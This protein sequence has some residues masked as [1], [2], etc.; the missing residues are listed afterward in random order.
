MSNLTTGI[1]SLLSNLTGKIQ[2]TLSSNFAS[3]GLINIYER[4]ADPALER[5]ILSTG[6]SYGKQIGVL[7]D[8][9]DLL[10]KNSTVIDPKAAAVRNFNSL[11]MEIQGIKSEY[12]MM[13]KKRE[14]DIVYEL[15]Q[16]AEQDSDQFSRIMNRLSVLKAKVSST[17]KLESD[18]EAL[19]F[20]GS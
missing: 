6:A 19:P 15:Q 8:V 9:I 7:S 17:E 1:G 3:L 18:F 13:N 4:A 10:V 12:R 11:Q 14:D 5:K 16:V 20:T 2:D